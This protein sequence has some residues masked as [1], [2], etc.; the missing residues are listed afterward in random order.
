MTEASDSV[1]DVIIVGAGPVGSTA[2]VIADRHGLRTLVVDA[3]TVVYPLPRAIHFDADIMRIF[4]FA[5]L[6]DEIEPLVRATSGGLHLGA[7]GEPIR[8]FRVTAVDG[9]LGWKPHY[10]FYQ[11]EIDALL[12]RRAA[13][14]PHVKALLGWRCEAVIQDGDAAIVELR[15]EDGTTRRERGR[16][17]IAADGASSNIRKR[18]GIALADYGFEEPWFI[19]DGAVRHE[20]QGPDYSIMYCDP[21]RPGTYVPGPR[22]HRRWEFMLLPD[23]NGQ[24][25]TTPEGAWSIISGVTPWLRQ[26]EIEIERVAIYEFHALVAER[27]RDGRI[28]LAG[29]AAHQTPPFYGQGMCHGIRDVRNLLWKLAAVLREGEPDGLLDTYQAERELHVRAIIDQSVANGRYICVLDPELARARDEEMRSRMAEPQPQRVRTFRDTIPGLITGVLEPERS[30]P[31][32]LLFPQPWVTTQGGARV[33]LDDVLGRGWTL[34][35]SSAACA[36]AD[37]EGASV[38]I[39]GRD[40]EDIDGVLTD[41][42]ATFR[43]DTVLLR[44]DRYVFGTSDAAGADALLAAAATTRRQDPAVIVD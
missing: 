43:C 10:M 22:R 2:A 35:G 36:P 4:Q 18:L 24:R 42:F 7:D 12:R 1:Y 32:G 33:R 34:I 8:D 30:A 13:E 15:G 3:S 44:P 21:A 14:A 23:E 6:A 9:D 31:V 11:P 17:V 16:Y 40:I 27:W 20:D 28:F 38:L 29:D 39:I 26:D 41:W 37:P 5:G 25:Y 19:I